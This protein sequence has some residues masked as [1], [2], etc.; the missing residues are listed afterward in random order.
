MSNGKVPNHGELRNIVPVYK[1][2]GNSLVCG[3]YQVAKL[4]TW[5]E[6]VGKGS[7]EKVE[8]GCGYADEMQF[9]CMLGKAYAVFI[10]GQIQERFLGNKS[11]NCSVHLWT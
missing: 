2:K 9:G 1:G 5:N 4:I 6:S 3:S 10:I 7:G 11:T 8:R